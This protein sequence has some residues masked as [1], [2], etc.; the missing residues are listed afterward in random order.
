MQAKSVLAQLILNDPD[1]I[2]VFDEE[3]LMNIIVEENIDEFVI[4]NVELTDLHLL[5]I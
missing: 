5:I 2:N 3:I 4:K 1:L